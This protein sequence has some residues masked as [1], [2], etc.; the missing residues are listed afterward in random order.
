M[1]IKFSTD[2]LPNLLLIFLNKKNQECG[3]G[4]SRTTLKRCVKLSSSQLSTQILGFNVLEFVRK[5]E[6]PRA[7]LGCRSFYD[8]NNVFLLQTEPPKVK[9][10]CRSL[11]DVN[12]VFLLQTEPPIAKLGCRSLY[13]VNNVFLLQTEPPTAKLGCRSLYDVNNLLVLQ[14]EPPS[15]NRD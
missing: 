6:P 1:Y 14:T 8:V 11:Y 7:K 13:D 9:L 10:G 15:S 5:T 12:N 2:Y 3:W 4:A